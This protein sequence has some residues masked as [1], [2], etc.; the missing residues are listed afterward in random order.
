MLWWVCSWAMEVGAGKNSGAKGFKVIIVYIQNHIHQCI[1]YLQ[2]TVTGLGTG[3]CAG[4]AAGR[5]AAWSVEKFTVWKTSVAGIE[6]CSDTLF[7][8]EFIQCSGVSKSHL[9]RRPILVQIVNSGQS[10]KQNHTQCNVAPVRGG[11]VHREAKE[12]DWFRP[13]PILWFV[14]THRRSE[15]WKHQIISLPVNRLTYQTE[16]GDQVEVVNANLK[17]KGNAQRANHHSFTERLNENLTVPICY[18]LQWWVVQWYTHMRHCAQCV[19]QLVN[20]PWAV[21]RPHFQIGEREQVEESTCRQCKSHWMKEH[22]V[23]H[24]MQKQPW[25]PVQI[26]ISQLPCYCKSYAKCLDKVPA[27]VHLTVNRRTYQMDD[28]VNGVDVNEWLSKINSTQCRTPQSGA[29]LMH[30]KQVIPNHSAVSWWVVQ[31]CTPLM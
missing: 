8:W 16:D 14:G 11:R 6:W 17:K 7:E 2:G 29:W 13:P 25:K 23:Q 10:I 21:Y 3:L 15:N 27:E 18:L 1:L 19:T 9:V 31:W 5:V 26:G 20:R 4:C 30:M 22:N 24:S 12:N 28:H